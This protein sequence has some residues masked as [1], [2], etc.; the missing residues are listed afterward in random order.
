MPPACC[1]MADP[2]PWRGGGR[3]VGPCPEEAGESKAHCPHCLNGSDVLASRCPPQGRLQCCKFRAG[4]E[5][6]VSKRKKSEMAQVLAGRSQ[7]CHHQ[8][9]E[10]INSHQ[11][12]NKAL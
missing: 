7:Q 10:T 5:L 3:E 12:R 9:H 2:G 8:H 4:C 6:L 11:E 1:L